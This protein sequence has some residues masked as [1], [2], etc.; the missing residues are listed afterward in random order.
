MTLHTPILVVDDDPDIREAVS[1][2]LAD[3]G[4]CHIEQAKDGLEALPDPCN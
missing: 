3:E 4:Y 2:L 1:T